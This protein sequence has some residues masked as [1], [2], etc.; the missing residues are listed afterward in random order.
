MTV[1]NFFPLSDVK[2]DKHF[3]CR[4]NVLVSHGIVGSNRTNKNL[5]KG[6]TKPHTKVNDRF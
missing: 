4:H 6:Q 5:L 1:T 2:Y 3:L